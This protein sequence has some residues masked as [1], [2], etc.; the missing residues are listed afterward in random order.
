MHKSK[1]KLSGVLHKGFKPDKC[2][3]SLRMAV[4]RIKLL[5]NRKEVQVRQMRREVVQL[6]EANQDMTARIR[7]EHVIREEKFMQAYD[8]IEVYCELIVARLS[9]IDSQKT[10]PIDLKEAVASVIFASMRCSDVTELADVRKHFKSKYGKEFEAAALEVRPDSG[11]N[12]LV[13]EKLSAVAPDIQTKIKTLS[14]IAEEHNIKWEPKAFEEK[15]Q[16]PNENPLYGSATYSGGNISTMGSSTSSMSTPQPTYSGVSATAVDSATSHVPVGPSPAHVPANR[17]AYG[18]ASSNTFSK[19]NIHDSS[20]ASVPPIS[21]HG[22]S[23]YTSAQTPGSNNISHG[24]PVGP[25]YPQYSTTVPDTASRNEE[26]NQHTERK[27]SVTGANWNVEFKDATSAAQAAAES[28]EMASI[29]ARAAAELASRGNY[30]GDKGTGAYDSA[31]YSSG[32]TPRKQHAEHIVKNEKSF[33]DQSSGVND[34]RVMPSNSRNNFGGTETTH[35][36]SQNVSTDKA[37][38]QQFHSYSPESHPY[39]YEMPTEPPRAHSPDPRFDDLYERESDIGRSEVHPFDFPGENLQDTG[40]VGRSFKDVEIRRSS[41]DQES[42]DDYYGN[43]N[44]SHDTFAHGSNTTAWDKQNDKAQGNSSPVVFDQYDS[45][46][47]EENLLDTFSSKHT[48]QLPGPSDHMGFSTTDWSEQHR[49]ESPSNQKTSALFSRTETQLS[50]NLGTNRSD[51]PSPHSY[52]NLGPAFDSDGGNSD[53]EIA[54]TTHAVSLRSHSGGS[55]SSGLNKGDGPDGSPIYDYSGAQAVRNLNRVQSRDS[56]LS[57]EETDLDKFKGS[58]SAGAN[59]QQSLPFAIHTSATSADKEGDLGLNFGRLTPGLRNKPRQ[60]PPYTKVSRESIL[61]RQPLP[62]VSSSTEESVDSE[63]NTTSKQNR[64]SPKSS[65]SARINSGKN[66]D[67]D[68]YERNQSVGTH[69]EARS[70]I[71]RNSSG[72]ADAEKV[73]ELPSNKSV[74]TT[75]SSER[76]N[77]SQVLYH[78]KPGIGARLGVRSTMARNY[79]DTDDSEEELEQQQPP[80]SKQSGVL[81]QS[82]RTREVTSDTKRD[83]RIQIGAQYDDETESVPSKTRGHQGFDSSST[84]QRTER[85]DASVYPRVAVQRSSPKAE[86]IESPMA[87]GKPQEAEMRRNFVR[88]NEGDTE[89][90]AGTP[91][92]STPKTPPAHVHPKLPTDY[93]SFAAHFRSL[94]TNRP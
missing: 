94:R 22:P 50:D 7:V 51:I 65:F 8:L 39:V 45:D 57:E 58:S 30:S 14:S 60:P 20:S 92:E 75:K 93:D 52:H 37:P 6:L 36:D 4:A 68:L 38:Y 76:A 48:E 79:F 25:P 24:N 77:S 88:G 15:L 85:R 42:T 78:E 11:V 23:A 29:A 35:V 64:S 12:R 80:Q 44:S 56:D 89:T 83:S 32:N 43:F 81:I 1:G 49:S 21:Q 54:T 61:P 41:S 71:A 33:H 31:A 10:C 46:V 27:P 5:R 18:S 62:T 55:A 72:F 66:Y 28:A 82:R 34:P 90:S 17:T 59:E 74:P 67:S 26:I 73:S 70:T 9:I 53:E 16:Q 84:E 3:T 69:W 40:P 63:E 19:E 2:K 87:R 91:K 47:E 13:I 86:Q